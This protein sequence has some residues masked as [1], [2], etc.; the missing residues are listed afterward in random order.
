MLCERGS[1]V[2]AILRGRAEHLTQIRQRM[3][4]YGKTTRMQLTLT[5]PLPADR[6]TVLPMV[7]IYREA[8]MTIC[9]GV[10]R[11]SEIEK[12]STTSPMQIT[13]SLLSIFSNGTGYFPSASAMRST[14]HW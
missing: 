1:Q 9:I 2:A 12:M 6:L 4:P 7:Q 3:Q 10:E 5:Q 14:A 13:S 11:I 8:E